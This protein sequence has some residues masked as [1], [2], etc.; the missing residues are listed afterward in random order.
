M[1]IKVLPP[2]VNR[3]EASFSIEDSGESAIRFGLSD[4]KNVG[5][6]AIT[7]IVE[8]RKK[9][10]PFKSL[11]DFCRRADLRGMNKKVMESLIKAGALDCL[12]GRGALL[13]QLDRI[14][15]LSQREQ[16]LRESGQATMFDLW[17]ATTP[18]PLPEIQLENVEVSYRDR[19]AWEKELIG[20]Y[21]SGHP[22]YQAARELKSS[23][24]AFCGEIN[25]DMVGQTVTV[26]GQVVSA[27][28]GLTKSRQPFVS[29]TLEDLDGSVEVTCWSSVYQQTQDLWIEGNILLIQGKVRARN[30]GAQL[31]CDQVRQ[32]EP[33]KEKPPPEPQAKRHRLLIAIV[34]TDNEQEDLKRLIHIVE[35]LKSHPGEDEV[36]LTIISNSE[37]VRMDLPNVTISCSPDLQSRLAELVGEKNLRLESLPS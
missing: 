37:K 34:Q 33:G 14:M 15:S 3:S 31:I 17:G 9:G 7:P 12:A 28:Q 16:S 30:D 22:F 4:I 18:T 35:T 6:G 20:V 36:S 11:E 2:D 25:A 27:R 13:N 21:L 1:D 26:A 24:T 32:Y 8:A 5:A 29:A 19:L 10:G 23:T